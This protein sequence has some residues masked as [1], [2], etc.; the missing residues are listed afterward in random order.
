MKSELFTPKQAFPYQLPSDDST[1]EVFSPILTEPLVKDSVSKDDLI[2]EIPEQINQSDHPEQLDITQQNLTVTNVT[3]FELSDT[4]EHI[5]V[6]ESG[7]PE[8]HE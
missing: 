2:L 5:N 1:L 4:L 7:G 3:D 8:W 6:D